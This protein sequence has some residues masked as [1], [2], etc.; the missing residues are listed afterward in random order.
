MFHEPWNTYGN[1]LFV[2]KEQ[3]FLYWKALIYS[4]YYL[5][6]YRSNLE[7]DLIDLNE[8][9]RVC[10]S[11]WGTN[12][13]DYSI[14]MDS[15][16]KRIQDLVDYDI[17]SIEVKMYVAELL[18][19]ESKSQPSFIDSGDVRWFLEHFA[20][21]IEFRRGIFGDRRSPPI[22]A[23]IYLLIYGGYTQVDPSHRAD[24]PG[25]ILLGGPPIGSLYLL[26]QLE[27]IFRR[28]SNYLDWDGSIKKEIPDKSLTKVNEKTKRKDYRIGKRVSDIGDALYFYL[29][30][31]ESILAK[32][33]SSLNDEIDLVNRLR[34]SRHGAAHGPVCDTSIESYLFALLISMFYFS[35]P[36][37][38]LPGEEN[39]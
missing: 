8:F 11:A 26:T 7:G 10:L 16:Y 17:L 12:K 29:A 24:I 6:I 34:E 37:G 38:Y 27:Y 4:E 35:E 32:S 25:A 22:K 9:E 3:L 1:I 14:L 21:E 31:N 28:K 2:K 20:K 18:I 5:R 33:I 19:R 13:R 15:N 39:D 23:S 30:D 36:K